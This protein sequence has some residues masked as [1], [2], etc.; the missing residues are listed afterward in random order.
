MNILISRPAHIAT[1]R[2][3]FDETIFAALWFAGQAMPLEQ[4]I[5]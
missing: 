1:V 4:A 3:Q 2:G 5:A